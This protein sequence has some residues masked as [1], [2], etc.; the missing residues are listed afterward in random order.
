[1]R[2][3]ISLRKSKCFTSP[4]TFRHID[5]Q[6]RVAS[7]IC[8]KATSIKVVNS[9]TRLNIHRD[10]SYWVLGSASTRIVRLIT[11]TI[12]VTDDQRFTIVG[13][14]QIHGDGSIDESTLVVTS[15]YFIEHTTGNGERNISFD[16]CTIRTTVDILHTLFGVTACNQ[17]VD[18]TIH[19]GTSTT[20]IDV[21]NLQDTFSLVAFFLTLI[22]NSSTLAVT[23]C[24]T[25]SEYTTD[26]TALKNN[27]GR[28]IDIRSYGVN[29]SITLLGLFTTITASKY[30]LNFKG[31]IDSH[32]TGRNV[33]R[34][35]TTVNTFNNCVCTAMNLH[36]RYL[37]IRRGI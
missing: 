29:P 23:P 12:Q 36:L 21:K 24:I 26:I 10:V 18:I 28:A 7:H 1:M 32:Q 9:G 22:F 19:V 17:Q 4:C 15:K 6:V 35:T 14:F 30:G 3:F 20:A 34:I 31:T 37:S 11:A 27:P 5:V 13:L 16:F 33:G 25:T 8:L 2:T